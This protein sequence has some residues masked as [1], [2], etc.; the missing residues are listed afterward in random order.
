MKNNFVSNKKRK[1]KKSVLDFSVVFSFA[2]AVFS[3]LS[4]TVFGIIN[5]QGNRVSYAA[6]VT[7]DSLVFNFGKN[8]QGDQLKAT[9]VLPGNNNIYFEVP[10]YFSQSNNTNPIFC[11]EYGSAVQDQTPYSKSTAITDYGLLYLLENSSYNDRPVVNDAGS[12]NKFVEGW[13]TQVAIWLYLYDQEREEK[14]SISSDSVNYL[15]DEQIS[16]IKQVTKIDVN[17]DQ[18]GT[19]NMTFNQPIY[20]K[21]IEPLIS[22]AKA[23]RNYNRLTV[24]K[25]N[26]SITKTSD[27][28]YYQSPVITVAGLNDAGFRQYHVS[29][30]GINGAFIVDE[31]G[32]KLENTNIVPG[33]KFY[34]RVPANEVTSSIQN[35]NIKVLGDFDSLEGYTYVATGLSNFQK[36]VSVTSAVTQLSA[37]TNVEFVGSPDTGMSKTQTIY[38]IGLVVLLCGVGIV[39]ANTKTA[40]SN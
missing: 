7:D 26:G 20:T 30:S 21:Y 34:V 12:T 24:T 37:E 28:Q 3:M 33:K 40:E 6:P 27:G 22:K 14:G 35:I 10:L 4:L 32:N 8:N 1:L 17:Y 31:S 15:T 39:Y 2:I 13:I 38:F 11:I 19:Y 5:S 16:A 18:L 25:G 23:Y 29:L 9:G 36:V